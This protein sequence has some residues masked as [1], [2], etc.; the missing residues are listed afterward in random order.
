MSR[1]AIIRFWY[2][3]SVQTKYL[4]IVVPA[5]LLMTIG[6][7]AYRQ[8]KAGER[9]VTSA[10]QQFEEV[11]QLVRAFNDLRARHIDSSR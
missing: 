1:S 9:V 5:S 7:N 4:L 3:A 6:G 8:H 11:G 2:R 10:A